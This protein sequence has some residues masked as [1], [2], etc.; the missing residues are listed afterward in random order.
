[1]FHVPD[2]KTSFL[3]QDNDYVVVVVRDVIMA[4]FAR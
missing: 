2:L 4:I 1:M 3:A